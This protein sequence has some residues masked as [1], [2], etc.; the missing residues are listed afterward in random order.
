MVVGMDEET[1]SRIKRA[2]RV[3]EICGGVPAVAKALGRGPSRVYSWTYPKDRHGTDG[4]IPARDQ[5]AL[6]GYARASGIDLCP[7]DF[8]APQDPA[9]QEGAE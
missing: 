8:F 9:P 5:E 6:L 4:Y 1:E 7:D 2:A 3:I